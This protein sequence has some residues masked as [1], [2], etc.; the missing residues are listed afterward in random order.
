MLSFILGRCVC[1]IINQIIGLEQPSLS[2]CLPGF[3]SI[4]L[5]HCGSQMLHAACNY[6][7]DPI[8]Y[9]AALSSLPPLNYEFQG[10]KIAQSFPC[11]HYRKI[12]HERGRDYFPQC[13]IWLLNS[14]TVALSIASRSYWSLCISFIGKPDVHSQT[15]DC[16]LEGWWSWVFSM[17]GLSDSGMISAK[18]LHA[19]IFSR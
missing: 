13:R 15:V 10:K 6:E 9:L 19:R 11:G 7:V 8:K 5:L 2:P 14:S 3:R 17:L 12:V 4:P 1:H 16:L 18:A